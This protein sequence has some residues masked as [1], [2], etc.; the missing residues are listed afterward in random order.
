MNSKQLK[1]KF[2]LIQID[3]VAYGTSVEM[4]ILDARCRSTFH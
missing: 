1:V 4:Q 2:S 3:D